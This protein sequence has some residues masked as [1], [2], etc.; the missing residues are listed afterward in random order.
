MQLQLERRWTE[1]LAQL[2][3]SGMGYQRVRVR[4]KAGR[5]IENALV[6]NASVLEVP[7]SAAAF[8]PDEIVEIELTGPDRSGR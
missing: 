3:E 7:D 4:L 5:A 2:P 1:K 8:R 6:F